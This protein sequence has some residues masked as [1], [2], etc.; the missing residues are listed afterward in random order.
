MVVGRILASYGTE[1][2]TCKEQGYIDAKR[3]HTC[4]P[5]GTLIA[6]KQWVQGYEKAEKEGVAVYPR[7]GSKRRGKN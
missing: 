2:F 4:C 6:R 3:G 1:V 5:W 7:F